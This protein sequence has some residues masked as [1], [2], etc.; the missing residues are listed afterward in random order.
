MATNTRTAGLRRLAGK[1]DGR[2]YG[3]SDAG[4]Q[5]TLRDLTTERVAANERVNAAQY[6][7]A[8]KRFMDGTDAAMTPGQRMCAARLCPL[9]GPQSLRGGVL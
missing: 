8:D 5:G 7:S 1:D 9:V 4:Y 2:M 3:M 6:E